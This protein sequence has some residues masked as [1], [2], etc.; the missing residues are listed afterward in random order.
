MIFQN[1][2]NDWHTAEEDRP[3]PR[4]YSM[5]CEWFDVEIHSML[6]DLED[7]PVRKN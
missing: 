3:Q 5:F 2:L 7:G 1:E 4:I 6:L